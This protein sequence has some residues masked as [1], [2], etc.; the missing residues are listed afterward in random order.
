M[1]TSDAAHFYENL[2][3]ENPFPVLVSTIDYVETLHGLRIWPKA[4]TTWC[5]GTDPLVLASYPPA[6]PELAGVVAR[7]DVDPTKPTEAVPA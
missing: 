7:L 2:F 6:R 4:P 3:A 1:L 5:Q